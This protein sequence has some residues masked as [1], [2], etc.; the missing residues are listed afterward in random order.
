M[1]SR[2]GC[3]GV[4]QDEPR[5]ANDRSAVY[6]YFDLACIYAMYVLS[7]YSALELGGKSATVV[8]AD[9]DVAKAA[10]AVASSN[11]INMG[12]ACIVHIPLP[13]PVSPLAY[14]SAGQFAC[15]C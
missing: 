9:A 6:V 13:R 2:L 5:N 10:E 12:Q 8:F 1:D 7:M 11:L 3:I 14:R 15:L 4:A